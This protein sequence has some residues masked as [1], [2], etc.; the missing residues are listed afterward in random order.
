MNLML[1]RNQ[2]G[3]DGVFGELTA[4]T[5]MHVAVTLEHA[6]QDDRGGYGPK[7]LPGTYTCVRGTHQLKRGPAFETFEITGVPSHSGILFHCGN[8]NDDSE[9]CVLLGKEIWHEMIT[10]SRETFATFMAL[11]AGADEFLL[12][13][14]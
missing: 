11:Q 10:K 12:V 6:F 14:R 13:V 4:E 5:G 9:G 2:T 1:S 3:K 7:L 8:C